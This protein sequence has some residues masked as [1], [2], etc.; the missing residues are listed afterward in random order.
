MQ[1]P[2]YYALL[3]LLAACSKHSDNV[4]PTTTLEGRWFCQKDSLTAY[5]EDGS[6][7]GSSMLGYLHYT[8]ITPTTCIDSL[9]NGRT[10]AHAYTRQGDTLV[11][12]PGF[13]D[14]HNF[15]Y[16]QLTQSEKHAIVQLTAHLL[17]LRTSTYLPSPTGGTYHYV[18]DRYYSR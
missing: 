16:L 11:I 1:K 18:F 4:A 17:H 8:R 3:I 2:H 6:L 12:S 14:Y 15:P 9:R 5:R 10:D 13:V 7:G